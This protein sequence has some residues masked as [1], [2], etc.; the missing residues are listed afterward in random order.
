VDVILALPFIGSLLFRSHFTGWLVV[1]SIVRV[2]GDKKVE[3]RTQMDILG[4]MQQL[5]VIP[6]PGS[7]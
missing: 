1:S 2:S 7:A 4:G 6:A 5:G 3:E